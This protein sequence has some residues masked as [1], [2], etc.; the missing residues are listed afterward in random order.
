[1]LELSAKPILRNTSQPIAYKH[2]NYAISSF[3]TNF[4]PSFSAR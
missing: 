3:S 4:I 1:M 2:H